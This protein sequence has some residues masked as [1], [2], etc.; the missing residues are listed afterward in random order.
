MS[1]DIS[2][3]LPG[4]LKG[5]AFY[6]ENIPA[7]LRAAQEFAGKEGYVASLPQIV[8][9][10]VKDHL[11]F[12]KWFIALS[13]EDVGRTAQGKPVV[14]VVHGA[15]ILTSP[16]RIQ[17]AYDTGL[18]NTG[19]AKLTEKEFRELLEGKLP[20]GSEMPI[21]SFDD[22]MKEAS[23]PMRYAIIMDFG[24]VQKTKSGYQDADGLKDNPLLIARCGGVAQATEYIDK[25][26]EKY[27]KTQLGQ[28][29]PFSDIDPEQR[30]GRLLFLGYCD[31]GSSINGYDYIS[32]CGRFVGVAPEA[33]GVREAPRE[34]NN[35]AQPNGTNGGPYRTPQVVLPN[36]ETVIEE[37]ISGTGSYVADACKKDYAGAVRSALKKFY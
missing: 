30:Q 11:P 37:I 25:A 29:H 34:K 35:A 1:E 23:L 21:F 28:W 12:N 31:Y 17:Q 20:D 14:A 15:G 5:A 13:E 27:N 36:L 19:A 4:G 7:A 33:Q 18:I 8:G 22:F 16:E 2:F 10:R 26:K 3:V 32:N 6:D 24:K 9:M